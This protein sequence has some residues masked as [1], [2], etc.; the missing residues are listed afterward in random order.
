LS[1]SA[2]LHDQLRRWDEDT[3]AALANRGLLRRAGKDLDGAVP[4]VLSESDDVLTVEFGAQRLRFDSRGP[5]HATCSCP[6]S[7]VCQ[8]I[9]SVALWLQRSGDSSSAIAAADIDYDDLLAPLRAE[10]LGFSAAELSKHAGKAGYRWAWQ[11]VQDLDPERGLRL[12]GE[13]NVIIG[14]TRPRV[15]FR[16]P[17]GGIEALIAD[18]EVGDAAKY[19]VAAVLAFQRAHGATISPPQTDVVARAESLDFGKDHA[20]SETS[21]SA[22]RDARARLRASVQTLL[23][24]C[25]ELGLSHL[26]PGIAERFATLAVWAQGA[27]DFRLARLLRRLGD[28]VELLLARAGAADEHALFEEATVVHALVAA[29]DAAAARGPEPKHLVG[30]ARSHYEAL[31]ELDLLGLGALPWRAAS[32][33]VGLTM[34]FWSPEEQSF[35][36]CTDARPEGRLGGFDPVARYS[37][38]GPWSGLGSPQQVTGRRVKLTDAQVSDGGR[39]SSSEKTT[40]E[41]GAISPD[42]FIAAL[43]PVSAWRALA[44]ARALELRS[45]LAEPEPLRD[46]VVL[47]PASCGAARFDATRQV[48]VWPLLDAEGAVLD[49]E[50]AYSATAR[51]AVERLHAMTPDRFVVGTLMVARVRYAGGRW[52][53]E[54]LSLLRSDGG[55]AVDALY[56]DAAPEQGLFDRA[57]GRLRQFAAGSPAP[58]SIDGIGST[59]P[60][61]LDELRVFLRRQAERGIGTA[62]VPRMRLEVEAHARRLADAGLT[63]FLPSAN[64]SPAEQ[65]LRAHYLLMQTARLLGADAGGD[66]DAD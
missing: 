6:T 38:P 11:F 10:L 26:S 20:L 5:A 31:G 48:L 52:V 41:V 4:T 25:I 57:L 40:A 18:A 17:G 55:I 19:R 22:R 32:G 24:E 37:Q 13:K 47:Q 35:L 63:G 61:S 66:E 60:A 9:L 43:A 23:C 49:V 59:L 14:F 62:A 39:L 27:D 28:H 33:Y 30:R 65:I 21:E 50:I 2:R 42:E 3:F 45:L 1:L 34:L 8:H 53:A 56:F 12:A 29:L 51:L 44:E 46:W 15:D 58:V 16:Y 54:P 36:S 7:G 64:L